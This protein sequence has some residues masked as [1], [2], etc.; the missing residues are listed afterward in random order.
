MIE[1]SQ[2][3]DFYS[4]SVPEFS[5]WIIKSG[6]KGIVDSILMSKGDKVQICQLLTDHPGHS[7]RERAK[8]FWI[9]FFKYKEITEVFF[10]CNGIVKD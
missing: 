1:N 10:T 7:E 4:K 2:Y 8:V 9:E 6:N 5:N 3:A